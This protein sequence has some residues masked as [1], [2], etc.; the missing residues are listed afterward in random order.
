MMLTR[1]YARMGMEVN[2]THTE[3]LVLMLQESLV[4]MIFVVNCLLQ[5]HG[6]NISD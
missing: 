3:T 2:D 5:K 1:R 4:N 6:Q